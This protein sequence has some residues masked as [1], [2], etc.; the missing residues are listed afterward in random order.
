MKKKSIIIL[1]AEGCNW[2]ANIIADE[3]N[4]WKVKL[5]ILFEYPRG[6]RAVPIEFWN[7]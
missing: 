2:D 6:G 1:Y 3:K 4:K 5:D 7:N